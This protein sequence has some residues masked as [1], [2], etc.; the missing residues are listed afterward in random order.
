MC[1]LPR[2]LRSLQPFVFV[3]LPKF[4][5]VLIVFGVHLHFPG[6]VLSLLPPPLQPVGHSP[7]PRQVSRSNPRPGFSKGTQKHVITVH[8]RRNMYTTVEDCLEHFN[9]FVS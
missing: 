9:S 3:S 2:F 1:C 6:Q 7:S 4:L 5:P 8:R